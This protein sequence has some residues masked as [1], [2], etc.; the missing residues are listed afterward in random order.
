MVVAPHT[1]LALACPTATCADWLPV[2]STVWLGGQEMAGDGAVLAVQGAHTPCEQNCPDGHGDDELQGVGLGSP[3]HP[4]NATATAHS[5]A[6]QPENR[7]MG[8]SPRAHE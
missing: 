5:R 8:P 2:H 1:S 4:C 3:P 6:T 7:S